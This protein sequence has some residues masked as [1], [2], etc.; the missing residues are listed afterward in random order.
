MLSDLHIHSKYSL[1]AMNPKAKSGCLSEPRDIIKV[2]LKRGLSVIAVTDH[3]NVKGG[4]NT[5]KESKNF[6]GITVIPG[7]EVS[8]K[9]GHIL[10]LNVKE[11]IKRAM[12]AQE[13]IDKIIEL[14]GYPVLAHPFDI[15]LSVSEKT[16][17]GTNSL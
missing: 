5:L 2:A 10:A 14:G 15:A 13:T 8:S 9:Q 12:S 4:I 3:D 16:I 17:S 7:V 6:K 11:D 1:N